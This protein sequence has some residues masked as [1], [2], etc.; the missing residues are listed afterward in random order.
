MYTRFSNIVRSV[1][2]ATVAILTVA[3]TD[4]TEN[5]KIAIIVGHNKISQGAISNS[6]VSEFEL[7]SEI[8]IEIKKRVKNNEVIIVYRDNNKGGYKNLP[9]K[10]N[11]IDPYIAIS[12]HA[13][14][15]TSPSRGHEVL[16]MRGYIDSARLAYE[17]NKVIGEAIGS[18][19]RGIKAK[20]LTD[21]GGYLLWNVKCPVVI[22]EPF[23]I[24]NDDELENF[25]NKKE[26]YI[27]SLV[28]YIDKVGE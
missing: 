27:N 24:N 2:V 13:N 20:Y 21:R 4:G 17:L 18:K 14:A 11:D 8:A 19:D 12:L 1:L 6:G 3:L 22:L 15:S 16:Y 23:F 7:N 25:M 5:K 9:S 28:K 26:A 10:V